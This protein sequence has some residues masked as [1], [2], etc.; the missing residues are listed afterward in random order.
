MP[1]GRLVGTPEDVLEQ[2]LVAHRRVRS[3]RHFRG[4]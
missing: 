2:I 3:G 4:E 1:P